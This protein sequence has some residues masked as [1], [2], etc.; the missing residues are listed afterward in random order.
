MK[1]WMF[2]CKEVSKKVS[3]SLDTPLP[4]GQRVQVW[5]H[6]L[7]CK[8]CMRLYRQL[9]MLRRYCKLEEMPETDLDIKLSPQAK[10]RIKDALQRCQD[11]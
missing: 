6:L 5:I 9:R 11:R 4:V 8:Y 1:Y 3:E 10:K 7:M 2:Q